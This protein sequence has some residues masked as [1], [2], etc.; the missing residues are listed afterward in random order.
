MLY[1]TKT[2]KH[3][4][5]FD[6]ENHIEEQLNIPDELGIELLLDT[7]E[8]AFF[9]FTVTGK[10]NSKQ[11]IDYPVLLLRIKK[12]VEE[13]KPIEIAGN[14]VETLL[15]GMAEQG[16]IPCGEYLIDYSW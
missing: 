16:Y 1:T 11:M 2:Y 9:H 7:K 10:L 6:L 14:D 4:A 8:G 3:I 13:Q 12:C 15:Q 5:I